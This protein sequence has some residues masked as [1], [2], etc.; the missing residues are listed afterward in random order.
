MQQKGT[1]SF[2]YQYGL[3]S[4][5]SKYL[6]LRKKAGVNSITYFFDLNDLEEPLATFL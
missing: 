1:K 3:V 6:N 4:M 2:S 5:G